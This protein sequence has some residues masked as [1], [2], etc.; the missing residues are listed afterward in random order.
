MADQTDVGQL[1]SHSNLLEHPDTPDI[2]D[3]KLDAIIVPSARPA[4]SLVHAAGLAEELNT[5]LVVLA[6]RRARAGEVVREIEDNGIVADVIAVDV[7]QAPRRMPDLETA[8]LLPRGTDV[9][10]KRNLGLLL[11]RAAGWR[12]VMFLDDDIT[13]KSALDLRRTAG[14]LAKHAAVGM[15]ISGMPDNSVVC[16]ARRELGDRQ[17][18]FIGGGALAVPTD[19]D[20]GAFFPDIYNE[21]WFF[22]LDNAQIRPVTLVGEAIQLPYDPF[23]DPARA[24]EEELGDTLAEGVFAMLSRRGTVQDTLND[25]YWVDFL[26]ARRDLIGDLLRRAAERAPSQRLQHM[27]VALKAARGRSFLIE[28]RE[29]VRFLRALRRDQDVWA[30]EMR[31]LKTGLGIHGALSHFNLRLSATIRLNRTGPAPKES[32]LRQQ[33]KRLE[34]EDRRLA[35][36]SR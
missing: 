20:V 16:H 36:T 11:A 1:L 21:D 2:V 29:C 6:S 33:R 28:P 5:P 13:V 7:G 22:L 24:R 23:V 26:K 12:Q 27:I 18:T 3:R 35:V 31:Q 34:A 4:S 14:A 19:S 30:E 25:G 32:R 9:S 17:G 15:H 8:H 10:M